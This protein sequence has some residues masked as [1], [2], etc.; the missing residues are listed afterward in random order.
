MIYEPIFLKRKAAGCNQD[1]QTFTKFGAAKVLQLSLMKNRGYYLFVFILAFPFLARAQNHFQHSGSFGFQTHY[2]SFLT[3]SPKA[4]YLR[5]SYTSYHELYYQH[6]TS[7]N[8]PWHVA[9]KLPQWGVAAFWGNTGSQQYMGHMAGAFGFMNVPL[10]KANRFTSK[11]RGAMGLG[12]VQKPYD[13]A[14]NHKNVLIGSPING[15]VQFLWQNELKVASRIFINAGLSFTHLSNGGS[16]LPNLG[17]NIPALSLGIRYGAGEAFA[18]PTFP[19]FEKEKMTFTLFASAGTK[20]APWVESSR[21]LVN[22]L[23]IEASKKIGYSSLVGGG[24]LFYYDRSLQVH[25]AGI[26]SLKRKGNFLQVGVFAA[27]EHQFGKVSVPLQLGAYVYNKDL[28]PQLFQNLGLRY[29]FHPNWSGQFILKTHM[30]QADHIHF[31]L[32][33][34]F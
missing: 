6:Q 4:A 15:F 28:S 2:G 16:T 5:D 30:G 17:L 23:S 18:D 20:Q 33:Y 9:N 8:K 14:T 11:L 32:G 29:R 19:Y 26:P 25:P 27:Y 12:W 34:H 3:Q 10:L 1:A 7:G 22:T 21:Y 24:A 13:K 31:G